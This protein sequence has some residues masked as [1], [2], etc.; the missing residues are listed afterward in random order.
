M[1][2]HQQSTNMALQVQV[3]IGVMTQRLGN[4]IN[5]ILSRKRTGG[6][7]VELKCLKVWT[8]T[9]HQSLVESEVR[10]HSTLTFKVWCDAVTSQITLEE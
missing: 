6:P 1:V 4:I 8:P 3:S 7:Y 5:P 2:T 9:A 10:T